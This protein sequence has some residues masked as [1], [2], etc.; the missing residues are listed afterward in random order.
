[1]RSSES[2]QCQG[3]AMRV[4]RFRGKV[5]FVVAIRHLLSGGM[6]VLSLTR[7][8]VFFRT[9]LAEEALFEQE[10]FRRAHVQESSLWSK[11]DA[12][13]SK[14]DAVW[15]KKNAAWSK[16]DAVYFSMDLVGST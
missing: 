1:M 14:R 15:S 12:V 5:V 6:L 11:R 4:A 9:L 10:R 7:R 8:G 3:Q 16:K 2:S 13:W